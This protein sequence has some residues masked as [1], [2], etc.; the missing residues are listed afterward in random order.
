MNRRTGA[1][2][3]WDSLVYQ[4]SCRTVAA[5]THPAGSNWRH[6]L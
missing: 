2:G 4:R 1:A 6:A 3:I 5:Q